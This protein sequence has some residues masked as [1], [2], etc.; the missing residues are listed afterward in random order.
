MTN[1]VYSFKIEVTKQTQCRF[2]L[3]NYGMFTI[4]L[5]RCNI[6]VLRT[7]VCCFVVT[8][9][10]NLQAHAR[11]LASVPGDIFNVH[12]YAITF[13]IYIYIY[14]H[15]YVCVYIYSTTERQRTEK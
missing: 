4:N 9:H 3:R 14:I 5:R 15:I 7:A 2:F 12:R 11:G 13:L 8:A 6:W 10:L 1:T